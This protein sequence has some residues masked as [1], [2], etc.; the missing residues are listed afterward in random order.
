MGRTLPA[1]RGHL[2]A[3]KNSVELRGFE[4]LAPGTGRPDLTVPADPSSRQR[5]DARCGLAVVTYPRDHQAGQP[6]THRR[7]RPPRLHVR[8]RGSADVRTM[9]IRITMHLLACRLMSAMIGNAGLR[10]VTKPSLRQWESD[11]EG[12]AVASQR[13]QK[14]ACTG[15][16]G[17]VSPLGP[18]ACRVAIAPRGSCPG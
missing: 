13:K 14:A 9:R 5:G 7:S 18:G 6:A 16:Y 1:G 17:R 3:C 11:I 10:A 4:P 12:H 8:T 15:V 2:P